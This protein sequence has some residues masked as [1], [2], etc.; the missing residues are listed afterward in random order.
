MRLSCLLDRQTQTGTLRGSIPKQARAVID[1]TLYLGEPAQ[2]TQNGE[3]VLTAPATVNILYMDPDGALQSAIV[4]DQA[5]CKIALGDGVVC[6]ASVTPGRD[7]FAAPSGGGID[8]RYDVSFH[9]DC[10]CNQALRTLTG[11]ELAEGDKGAERFCVVVRHADKTQ[12]LWDLA[13]QYRTSE[14]AIAGANGITS[15]EAEQG[16]LLLIPV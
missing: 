15:G 8:V 3:A 10:R 12:S 9:A 6:E 7:G 5:S 16:A 14:A 4:R 1:S 13:K 11:G 2:Q